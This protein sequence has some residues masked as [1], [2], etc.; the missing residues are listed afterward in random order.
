MHIG[1]ES[2]QTEILHRIFRQVR[3]VGQYEIVG[4]SETLDIYGTVV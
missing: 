3:S 2:R 1:S 4:Q